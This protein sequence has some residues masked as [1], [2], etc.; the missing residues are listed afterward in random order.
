M[1]E[2]PATY[3]NQFGQTNTGSNMNGMDSMNGMN[4]NNRMNTMTE[5]LNIR[6][7]E[8]MVRQ[9]VDEMLNENRSKLGNNNNNRNQLK[10]GRRTALPRY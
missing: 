3:G 6:Q 8:T 1:G 7:F 2:T 10:N 4:N 5:L 9:I